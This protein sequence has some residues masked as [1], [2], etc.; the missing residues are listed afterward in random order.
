MTDLIDSLLLF[1]RTGESLQ[2]SCESLP[3]LVERAQAIVRAHPDAQEVHFTVAPM[4]QIEAWLDARKVE[5]A[6]YNLL[7][8]ACQ[9]AREGTGQPEVR[10][11]LSE[12]EDSLTFAISDN[13]LGVPDSVRQSLFQP[14]VSLGK[15]S[16]TGLGLTL[17]LKIAQ[18][19]GGTVFLEDTDAGGT[20]F[21]LTLSK[22]SL[23]KFAE[24]AQRRETPVVQN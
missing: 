10:I 9:A 1:S 14:F 11:A 4:P 12:S 3:F 20:T 22:A 5:R 21:Q 2:L 24:T 8:N 6:V 17:S 15:P 7:L 19:H 23:R 13:G 18:E 16:G